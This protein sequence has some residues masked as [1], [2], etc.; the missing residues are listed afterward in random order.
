[1]CSL[2]IEFCE[3]ESLKTNYVP[4][5]LARHQ[6]KDASLFQRS[7]KSKSRNTHTEL[8]LALHSCTHRCEV[9]HNVRLHG[10]LS[11]FGSLT[12]SVKQT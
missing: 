10:K 2:N 5:F 11:S 12:Y 1:M 4:A 9:L 8:S 3:R 6:N 7:L